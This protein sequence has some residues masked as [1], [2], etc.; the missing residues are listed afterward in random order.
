MTLAAVTAAVSGVYAT[1]LT[2]DVEWLLGEFSADV[3]LTNDY[4][5]CGISRSDA[6]PVL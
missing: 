4:V 5:F 6:K 1:E 2:I 3:A